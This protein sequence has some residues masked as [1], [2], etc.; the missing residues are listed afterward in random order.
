M[1]FQSTCISGE[2][3][4][5]HAA[6]ISP[7]ESAFLVLYP[8]QYRKRKPTTYHGVLDMYGLQ[9][10]DAVAKS[11]PASVWQATRSSSGRIS[12]ENSPSNEGSRSWE[13]MDLYYLQYRNADAKSGFTPL[14]KSTCDSYSKSIF[15]RVQQQRRKL[16]I[17]DSQ[18]TPS[19][20]WSRW[21]H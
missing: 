4:T 5:Q 8:D 19:K 18:N 13:T 2:Q 21:N 17:N 7:L 11:Q 3:V 12:G 20:F 14:W 1:F 9:Y 6:S 10:R 16:F 15:P